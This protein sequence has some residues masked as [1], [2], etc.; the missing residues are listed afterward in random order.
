[1]KQNDIQ[2]IIET[3]K[4]ALLNE[5]SP[6][7]NIDTIEALLNGQLNDLALSSEQISQIQSLLFKALESYQQGLSQGTSIDQ[8]L[9]TLQSDFESELK[10]LF[11]PLN[12]PSSDNLRVTTSDIEKP[13]NP[14][15][16]NSPELDKPL[17]LKQL[18]SAIRTELVDQSQIQ[19]PE[20]VNQSATKPELVNVSSLDVEI[21]SGI[22]NEI[23][24]EGYTPAI[25]ATPSLRFEDVGVSG[26]D[27]L[28]N[29]PIIEVIGIEQGANWEYSLDAGLTWQEGTATSFELQQDGIYEVNQIQVRQTSAEGSLSAIG[30]NQ[31]PIHLETIPVTIE[32]VI[33]SDTALKVG[34]TAT[35]TITF[36]E[37]VTD[38]DNTDITLANG[39]LTAVASNDGGITWTATFTPTDDIEDASNII[40]VG[41]TLTDLAGNAPLASLDSANYTIDTTEPVINSVTLSDTALKVGDTATLTITFSEAV[42]DF[43][44]T[45][46]TLANGTLTAVASNN[47]G[48]TWTATFTPTDDIEDA[49]NIITVGTTLTDLAG[50]APLASL[51]SAN[52]TIDTTEPVINSVTL[53]DT[54]L[55]VG[56][57]ATL[58]I[59][60]SEAVTDFDNTDITL[61]NGTLTA[62]ASNNGGITWTATFTPTDDIEDAS[63][64]ITVGTTLTDLAGNAPLASLDSANY[65][66]DTTEPVINSVTLSDTALKVGDTATLTITFSEAVT[67]FDNTD[68]TLANG[69]LTAVASN[70]GGITW[71]ATF[72]PTDDIEDASNIITVG[73]TLTDLAGNAPLA[74][75]DSAN[76]TIDT[77]EPVINSV[78][79]SDTA[80]KVGDTAT[81]TIT[82][83]EAVTDF[84]NTDITLANGTLTAVASNNGGITWTATFTPT[85]D[86]EDASNIITVGT[87]LTDL[88]GNAPLA[89]LDSANYTIDTTEPVINSVTLSDTALKVGDTA[90]LTITFSEA[91]TDFDNTD[92]TL[93][94]G[95]LTAVASNDGG[96]T[97]TA[98]FTPTDDIEDASNIIT[99][100]TTLTDLA[101]NAPLASLDSA[102]YTIDTTEPVI[103][104]V[105]LSDTALKVGDTATLTITFSEAVTD[106]DN[107][108][109]TLANGT[110]TAVASNDGGITWTAT[111]TPTDDIEDASNIITVGTTLTDLAGNAPLASLDSA[112]Y[113]IDTTEPVI[114]SVTLSDTALKVGDTATL[115]ITFSEAVTDF[116][117]T[118]IT[119]ANGTLTAVASNN[120]GITWT[121]TFTPTDDIEDASNIITVGTTL[122]DLAGNAPLASLDSANYTIDT[123]E[124]VINSVTLSDTALKVGD[125]ATLTITF[126]EAVT[127]FDNTD[128]TLANGTLT[129]VA[130]NDGGITW[131][132]TFTPTDDIEDASNIITVGTTLTDLAGNAPLASLDSANYTIDTTE[133]VI[134]SVTLSDTA[135]KVGDTA[136]LTITFSEAVTD[137]DNTDITLANGTLTAVASNDGGITWTATFTPTDDIEDASNIITVGTTLTDLAGNAPLASLDSANYTID[138]TEPVINSVTLSDTALKVGDTATLTITFSEAV[139]D[140][141]NTDITLA[142]GTLT[143]VAS[144][145]G[146][147]TW[148]ATFT[149][150]DDIED[151]SNIIT[152][153]T[154]LTDLAGNAPLASL[155]SA[156]YT[157]DTTEP[158]INS[159]ILSDT[160]LKVGDTATLTITFSE[161]VTDFDNTDITLANGTLTA[162][163]SNDGGITWTATFTPTDDIED[164]SNIITVGTTLT[165]LA[166][167]APLASLD[168][169]NYTIDTTEPVINSVTL[170]DTALKVG[171]TATLTITFSEAVTDFDNTDITLANGTLTAVASN[172]GGITWTATFTPTD[173][174]EDASNIITVGT[175]LTDLAG[176]APLA[177]LD[178]ANYTIDTTEP[179][180]NSVTL[181]DTALKVG[182]T[183]TLTITFSEAVTD[184]D[185]TDITLANGTLTAV[186]SNNGGITW[187]ATFTPTDDIEDASNIITVGTTLTDL[188]GNAPLASLDSANYTIDTT[189]PVINSVALTA[190]TGAQN[191]YLNAGDTIT[192]TVTFSEAVIV[193]ITNGIPTLTL[194]IGGTLVQA[195]YTSGSSSTHLLFTYTIQANQTDSNGISIPE[196]ALSLNTGTISDFAGNPASLTHSLVTDNPIYM[197]DTTG[198]GTGSTFSLNTDTGSDNSDSITSN[199]QI[200]VVFDSA[201]TNWEYSTDGGVT[202]TDGTGTGTAVNFT[203]N[204]GTYDIND[205]QVRE[206]GVT[207]DAAG[208]EGKISTNDVQIIIDQTPSTTTIS[209]VSLSN[210]TGYS[211][212]DEITNT[213]SQT[214]SA[215]LSSVLDTGDILYG[216]VDN[217]STWIDI[218]SKVTDTTL[219]WDGATLSGSSSIVFKIEDSAG[220]EAG[221]LG[222]T[223]YII[224]TTTPSG[225]LLNA[226]EQIYQMVKLDVPG[227]EFGNIYNPQIATSSL[228]DSYAVTWYGNP[229]S[230]ANSQIYV[231]IFNADG[232][233]TG[234]SITTFGDVEF[235]TNYDSYVQITSI[236]TVG[237]YAIAWYGQDNT[238]SYND[239]S[240]FVQRLNANGEAI[241][242]AVKLEATNQ[243]FR[244]DQYPQITSV[245][246][247]GSYVVTWQ[248]VRESSTLNSIYVQQFNADGTTTGNIP[249][250]LQGDGSIGNYLFPQ[251][252]AIGTVGEYAVTWYGRDADGD[253]SIYVQ[254]FNTDGTT[255]GH[256]VVKLEASDNTAGNDQKPQ[257]TPVGTDGSYAVTW[258]GADGDDGTLSIYVQQFNADGTTTGNA[259]VKLEA[260]DQTAGNDQLPQITTIGTNGNYVVTWF[261]HNAD[262]NTSIYI[263][264]FNPDGTVLGDT[265]KL[266]PFDKNNGADS[267]PQ[268]TSIGSDGSFVVTWSGEDINGDNSIYLQKF[269]ADG[270]STGDMIKLEAPGYISGGDVNP[271]I[272][273]VGSDGGFIVTWNGQITSGPTGSIYVQQF[274]ADGSTEQINPD[275]TN[276]SGSVEVQSSE[277]GR[278]YLVNSV[279]NVTSIASIEALA[280]DQW[281]SVDITIAD[282]SS[283]LPATGL[284]EGNYYLYVADT[285]GNLS[286]KVEGTVIV[287]NTVPTLTITDDTV[288]TATGDVTYTF[289]FSEAVTGFTVDDVLVS[290]GSKATNFAS[291]SDGDSIYTLVV[292][293]DNNSISNMT[294]NISE[295]VATD[296]AGNF[297]TAAEPNVQ[298]VDTTPEDVVFDLVNGVSSSIDGSRSFEAN[299]S[300]NIYLMVDSNTG[301]LADTINQ[302]NGANQL[303]SDDTIILVGSGSAIL[304]DTSIAVT[305]GAMHNIGTFYE[306]GTGFT[307]TIG[308]NLNTSMVDV[309]GIVRQN[310]RFERDGPGNDDFITWVDYISSL[311]NLNFSFVNTLPTSVAV[312]T[313]DSSSASF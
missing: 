75:L 292:T 311:S 224:D 184:F 58:T 293:P 166:G 23:E 147:I 190:Q 93:A 148:T 266:D 237:E 288:G 223:P 251:I 28:L 145:D 304:G 102:N 45:D 76:Y 48:I 194:D 149:P 15:T 151:A 30:S 281:N 89:S 96:I 276:N 61:A 264:R 249:V 208:N 132:A 71:T 9:Q 5:D 81:L 153:G 119:L 14:F 127:D 8:L 152:V 220:N 3:T 159:V 230:N 268:V 68:I 66:I 214:I 296:V 254:Q 205:I 252:T 271:Q 263:Q 234:N 228:D 310:G 43:D 235:T 285:A 167:N 265:V 305:R 56:D 52:Y 233:I 295:N 300:Y 13:Q 1:M 95:T 17:I 204:E 157:I 203:L 192:A 108:D 188:A 198:D 267:N 287:D 244:A 128:I 297:N 105:T 299:I 261:G 245:G 55:K 238:S 185:N 242:S 62:V 258:Q 47:G 173:D 257:I 31:Q 275:Y 225:T 24:E 247:D 40:T 312:P 186:A 201:I 107:T 196:N 41:T 121:A 63:N 94:N 123:T 69:T 21:T 78:T 180:I 240:I 99:V 26:T 84:D 219:N 272:T 197:V 269:S 25:P 168:S 169:A 221:N 29:N 160:A 176:N 284:A 79:L 97:W 162:V 2:I 262:F 182:D 22:T 74:L 294:V 18:S 270:V 53:S 280:D 291:G 44:N 136:T 140:F 289:S 100:G 115:T 171:D 191:N 90:T 131:T 144:N 46:I 88:A 106:F 243:T 253:D 64:I 32:S 207:T 313:P 303:G 118:D 209:S 77:T 120:G 309:A 279:H 286:N 146:G 226:S 126:S 177:S 193:D 156:N 27:G 181:S 87:T 33:V 138:T 91:V 213:S 241:G 229:T 10:D 215:T 67:D 114:N 150:T 129:A 51:D 306:W 12:Q 200:D 274:F 122:T 165:D 65:T 37:A 231:Q 113:T 49:S 42:T 70:D 195:S 278:A 141:D 4:E 298:A 154:T 307:F 232:S 179:V 175:T 112:N 259:I 301:L 103:N 109:I 11:N 256:T 163:A 38:F 59:T 143:A 172:D 137:F 101:G 239:Y 161:A 290:N 134:N 250:E 222:L 211:S 125:T 135:L 57:T 189:E 104:S 178:S 116:D 19:K 248:G 158:V 133:P 216:S 130:S 83:S 283:N 50:N 212:T 236:G 174:I 124:P 302:W 183:A 206:K 255:T 35:L 202:W 187:T 210:D 86:I 39:T 111:F 199:G 72:T 164:A 92:I 73:T 246:T 54:A 20:L 218:T 308:G 80:L 277:T 227:T 60:F 7:F 98:T 82:F 117:N 273:S 110:L 260:S 16:E 85:D 155:D 36:S 217:G 139:T 6:Q 34:D 142:N 170:S 282:T